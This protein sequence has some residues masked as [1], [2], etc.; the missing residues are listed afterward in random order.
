LVDDIHAKGVALDREEGAHA[1]RVVRRITCA[2]LLKKK[3]KNEK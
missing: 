1:P 3:N 2:N